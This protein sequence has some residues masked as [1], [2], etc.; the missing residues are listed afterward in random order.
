MAT[1]RKHYREAAAALKRTREL[2]PEPE[3]QAAIATLEGYLI[4]LFADDNPRFSAM[5]FK[6]ASRAE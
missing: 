6:D 4:T 3:A 2:F 5:K 1:T